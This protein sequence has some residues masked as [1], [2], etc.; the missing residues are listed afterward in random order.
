MMPRDKPERVKDQEEDDNSDGCYWKL[1]PL[2]GKEE[3][4]AEMDRCN[5]AG[6]S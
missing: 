1:I 5:R 2:D 6:S 3:T 4:Y